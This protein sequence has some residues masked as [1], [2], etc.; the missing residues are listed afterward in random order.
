M[1]DFPT[2]GVTG[3]AGSA[4][5]KVLTNRAA[6]QDTVD[7]V[8]ALAIIMGLG[9][10]TDQGVVVTR[11][12]VGRCNL[13]QGAV[14][15]GVGGMGRFPTTGMTIDTGTSRDPRQQ[16]WDGGGMTEITITH[17]GDGHCRIGPDARIV[18]GLTGGGAGNMTERHMIN[19]QVDGQLFVGV[20]WQ[21]V[22][23]IGT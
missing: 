18:T 1:C 4:A 23:R 7:S 15:R 2:A 12:T 20:T 8:T 6:D 11:G 16:A 22:G 21:T 9:G 19:A 13:N 10:G 14:I 17:M 5:G 3:R